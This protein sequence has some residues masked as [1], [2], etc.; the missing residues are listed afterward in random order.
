M[1]RLLI[2]T[3]LK[4]QFQLNLYSDQLNAFHLVAELV[5]WRVSDTYTVWKV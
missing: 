4:S 3:G 1:V 2:L 5:A